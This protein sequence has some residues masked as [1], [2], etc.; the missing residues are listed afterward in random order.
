MRFDPSGPDLPPE[1]IAA[2][3]HGE[4]VFVCGAGVS[5]TVGLPSFQKLVTDIYA[6]LGESWIDH[7]AEADGMDSSAYDR[8]IRC[9]E[10]PLGGDDPKLVQRV[11]ERIREA[12]RKDL[13]PP[14]ASFQAHSDITTL[15]RDGELRNRLVTTNF[16]TLFERAWAEK[17]G[18]TNQIK[19]HAGASMPGPLAAGFSGILHLHGRILD[20]DLNLDES[21]LV[22]TSAEFGEAYLRSGWAA[23]YVY[24]LVR[25]TTVVIIGYTADDPP[26]RY[27]LEVID[28]DRERFKDLRAVYAFVPC[29]TEDEHEQCALWKSKGVI[30]V[31]YET[32]TDPDHSKLYVAV[33]LW[34]QYAEDPTAWR[35]DRMAKLLAI[36]PNDV[37][38]EQLGEVKWLLNHADAG[39]NLGNANPSPDWMRKFS[40]LGSLDNKPLLLW[41]WVVQNLSNDEMI[42]ACSDCA[43]IDTQF[44]NSLSFEL[45]RRSDK[46]N[47]LTAAAWR[48]LI[49]T[50]TSGPGN[51]AWMNSVFE[52]KRRL[53]QGETGYGVIQLLAEA[54]RPRASA[55]R[56]LIL[57]DQTTPK[58]PPTSVG[59]ILTIEFHSEI[60]KAGIPEIAALL[61]A[62]PK[63]TDAEFDILEKL[64]WMLL[65]SLDDAADSGFISTGYD[66]T[67]HQV[68]SVAAHPQNEYSRGFYPVV[69]V[70]ADLWDRA[71]PKDTERGKR[72]AAWCRDQKYVLLK[73]LAL[74]FLS[75]KTVY[76]G[77][78]AGALLVGLPDTIFWRQARREQMRLTAER[79]NDFPQEARN[80]LEDRI[81]A[82]PPNALYG[83]E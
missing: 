3:E 7:V 26:M 19:S 36:P 74:H 42:Q 29:K 81:I 23:R 45:S 11:R 59:D 52:S 35:N 34:A 66:R 73:R 82:G 75:N 54:L 13:T 28:A 21:D 57:G 83:G 41:P 68:P 61:A 10:R 70:I 25:A 64:A 17:N 69:R 50:R 51:R 12:V 63:D 60:E 37:T 53:Q 56:P 71:A 31:P 39:G 6:D 77:A 80:A 58:S 1:L 78:E 33:H 24:D 79:W 22:L 48:V 38:N 49:R 46:V 40:E 72:F 30:P 14:V 47:K 44:F 8:V 62:V 5:M 43:A 9:L 2:Q 65:D 27:L 76:D 16:D 67:S 55:R 15:S 4:V 20:A 18:S 32:P